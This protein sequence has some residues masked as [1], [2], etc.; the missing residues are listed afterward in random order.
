MAEATSQQLQLAPQYR[1][2]TPIAVK[3]QGH[4]ARGGSVADGVRLV[5]ELERGG[6]PVT[7]NASREKR[8]AERGTR[9]SPDWQPSDMDVAFA[10]ER[11]LSQARIE[12]EVEKF[13]NYWTA[14][15]GA[16]ACKRDWS[17]CWRNWIINAMERGYGPSNYRGQGPGTR[18][19][20]NW[21]TRRDDQHA[22]R[23]KLRAFVGLN[24][25]PSEEE[26]GSGG[27]GPPFRLVLDARRG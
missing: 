27:D 23:A 21:Q 24:A 4:F 3:L 22:A 20:A 26:R 25:D 16:G 2:S 10:L 17:A 19:S 11:G 15:S 13:R 18:N 6:R 7:S 14:K 9:L 5:E 1:P 8:S 12:T